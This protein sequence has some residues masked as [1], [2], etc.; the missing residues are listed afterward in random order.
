M[1]GQEVRRRIVEYFHSDHWL[2][3][4]QILQRGEKV[5]HMH[6]HIDSILHPASLARIVEAYYVK[7]GYTLQRRIRILPQGYG[8]TN[9]YNIHIRQDMAHFEIM[10]RYNPEVVIEPAPLH[11]IRA[12]GIIEYWDEDFMNKFYSGFKFSPMTPEAEK[13]LTTFFSS[14]AWKE[15]W[16]FMTN[17]SNLHCHG[18]VETSLHPID[19]LAYGRKS[20][21]D[22]G[23]KLAKAVSVAFGLGGHD[24]GKLVF[25]LSSP[26]IFLELQW[27]Y[28]QRVAIQPGVKNIYYCL[29]AKI[30][31]EQ[32]EGIH[33]IELSQEQTE[34]ITRDLIK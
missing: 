17:P 31:K 19:I 10:I 13:A 2:N 7:K 26:Q 33:Y 27:F 4:Q 1:L 8:V 9:I 3:V 11:L 34:T 16:L 5:Y 15:N 20:L 24:Q 18:L 28:N 22:M 12:K 21:E 14:D 25:L 32:M 23:W 29:D 30:L 6:V